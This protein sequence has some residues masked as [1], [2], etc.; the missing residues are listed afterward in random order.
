MALQRMKRRATDNAVAFLQELKKVPFYPDGEALYLT[1]KNKHADYRSDQ[2]CIQQ[3]DGSI[4]VFIEI[5]SEAYV[6]NE[7]LQNEFELPPVIHFNTVSK[8]YWVLA[9]D[10]AWLMEERR[11]KNTSKFCLAKVFNEVGSS[12]YE[13]L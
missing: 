1:Y 4:I 5:L 12:I 7:E 6:I 3:V 13:Y 8:Y 2:D 10:L 11:R 9:L